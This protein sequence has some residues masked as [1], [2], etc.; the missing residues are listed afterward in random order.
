[1]AAPDKT[2]L[3]LTQFLHFTLLTNAHK[4]YGFKLSCFLLNST[5][6]EVF[7][8]TAMYDLITRGLFSLFA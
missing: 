7:V 2:V 1:M 8:N 6:L 5:S 3:V 4:L